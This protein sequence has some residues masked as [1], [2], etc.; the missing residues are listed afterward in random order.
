MKILLVGDNRCAGNFGSISTTD[1]LLR[2]L[3]SNSDYE[4]DMISYLSFVIETPVNGFIEGDNQK[5]LKLKRVLMEAIK[6]M[7]AATG[8]LSIIR[9]LYMSTLGSNH[10]NNKLYVPSLLR[11]YHSFFDENVESGVSFSYEKKM[12]LNSDIVILNAEGAF[13]NGIDDEGRYRRDGRYLLFVAYL[14]A[15][16]NKKVAIFNNVVDPDS[17]DAKEMLSYVYSIIDYAQVRDRMSLNVLQTYP[18]CCKANYYPDALFNLKVSDFDYLR[19][20][21]LIDIDI[22]E[23][24]YVC[25]GDSATLRLVSWDV[26]KFYVE[27]IHK[28]KD[29]FSHVVFIEG[30]SETNNDVMKAI[31]KTGIRYLSLKNSDYLSVCKVIQSA[32]IFLSGRWHAT[33]MSAVAGTPFILWGSDSHK[34]MSLYDLFEYP[35]NFFEVKTLSIHV[36]D[37]VE[38]A[39]KVNSERNE[40]VRLIDEHVSVMRLKTNHIFDFLDTLSGK[41]LDFDD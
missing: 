4:I 22:I 28:L 35:A 6:R 5:S 30:F 40:F 9:S 24:G 16:Y 13:V 8:L 12:I 29:R 25:L 15:R 17:N 26:E 1:M 31:Q 34:T 23:S 2:L 41:K 32:K 21:D 39:V 27:L 18:G 7:L 3:K 36:D 37:I 38:E 14:A 19:L 20:S 33:I 10:D 11:E